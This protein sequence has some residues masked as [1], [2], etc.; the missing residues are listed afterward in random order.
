MKGSIK[1]L[2]I[3]APLLLSIGAWNY[4]VQDDT[5]LQ[6][7]EVIVVWA[8]Y[9]F[10]AYG[11]E[12]DVDY[13]DFRWTVVAV[14]LIPGFCYYFVTVH[15]LWWLLGVF[16]GFLSLVSGKGVRQGILWRRFRS[17]PQNMGVIPRKEGSS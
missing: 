4:L 10:L 12:L 5:W 14:L 17:T 11:D 7:F 8:A 9:G 15:W 13:Q 1:D 2:L 3:A 16:V 6:I